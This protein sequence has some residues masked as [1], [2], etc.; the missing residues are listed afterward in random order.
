MALTEQKNN[1]LLVEK[2]TT[3]D[4][5]GVRECDAVMWV[6]ARKDNEQT[7]LITFL[8]SDLKSKAVKTDLGYK[9]NV[10]MFRRQ[11]DPK[12]VDIFTAIIG[13]PHGYVQ[14]VGKLGYHGVM[15]KDKAGGKKQMRVLFEQLLTKFGYDD[16]TIRKMI[17]QTVK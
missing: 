11:P 16:K 12:E 8:K 10:A 1:N 7:T 2:F 13:D 5:E 14:R 3:P 17:R 15:F 4:H 6:C 9:Y